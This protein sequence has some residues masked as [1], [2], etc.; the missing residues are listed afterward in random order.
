MFVHGKLLVSSINGKM[1]SVGE[2][3]AYKTGEHQTKLYQS[4]LTIKPIITLKKGKK[5]R[6]ATI[7]QEFFIISSKIITLQDI[8]SI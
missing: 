3:F 6:A 5:N 8:C 7:V 4:Q 1:Y 2:H